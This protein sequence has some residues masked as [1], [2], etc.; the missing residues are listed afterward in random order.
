MQYISDIHLEFLHIEEVKSVI[1]KIIPVAPIL[2]LAGDKGNPF[3]GN[4]HY[5]LF[6]EEMGKKF[7]KVFVIAGNHEYYGGK[8]M[9]DV[10]VKIKE[11][12]KEIS[13]TNERSN[14][15]Y[16]QNSYEEYNGVRW[17]GTTLWSR[18]D[19]PSK[20][21]NDV[22]SIKAMNTERY[23]ELH[24]LAV[25]N[26]EKMLEESSLPTIVITH[27]MP[28]YSLIDPM[29][30][31]ELYNMW[32]AS[33]LDNIVERYKEKIKYWIYGHTHTSNQSEL[34]G[35][36]MLCNPI[37]YKGENPGKNYKACV[38]LNL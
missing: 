28:S 33:D 21:I 11:I 9:T 37:G 30:N 17:I 31:D 18:L 35:V 22:Y 3:S 29:Y 5:R 27:H 19:N 26:L 12:V 2:I 20:Q 13:D 36:M 38:S 16:L 6:L 4:S 1:R 24:Y 15:T 32:F 34:H 23:N 14:I 10:E 7:E 8:D 25:E